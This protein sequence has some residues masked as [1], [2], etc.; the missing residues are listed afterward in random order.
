MF[1]KMKKMKKKQGDRDDAQEINAFWKYILKKINYQANISK[2][3]RGKG[4]IP[5]FKIINEIEM[6]FVYMAL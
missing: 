5:F 3:E 6:Y 2:L 4:F 1:S